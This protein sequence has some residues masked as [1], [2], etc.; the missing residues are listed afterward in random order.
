MHRNNSILHLGNKLFQQYCVD[1]CMKVL[2]L[3][4]LWAK[5]NQDKLRT[6]IWKGVSDAFHND[7][8]ANIGKRVI[9]PSSVTGSRRYLHE[10]YEDAMALIRVFGKPDFFITFT[11]NPNW[12][13]IKDHLLPGQTASD[14]PD[15]VVRAFRI[16]NEE[17]RNLIKTKGVFGKCLAFM[18]VIEFQK[19]L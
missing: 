9:C 10:K 14:R 1:Q 17:L 18:S 19:R 13:E 6:D 11:C 7:D 12:P 3:R 16:K 8:V 2:Q 5:E 4:V 15:L